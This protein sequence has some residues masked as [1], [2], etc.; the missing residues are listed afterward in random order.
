MKY[1]LLKILVLLSSVEKILI[2]TDLKVVKH[3]VYYWYL[4]FYVKN[5]GRFRT[6]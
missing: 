4:I 5:N 3:E 1:I 6:C 2:V